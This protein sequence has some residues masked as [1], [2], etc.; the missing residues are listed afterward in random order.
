MKTTNARRLSRTLPPL[1][2]L[3]VMVPGTAMAA[4]ADWRPTYDLVMLWVNF[5]IFSGVLYKY[6]RE[7]IKRFLNQQK[8][9]V[10]SQ[11]EEIEAEK[12]RVVGEIESANVKAAENKRRVEK[13]KTRLIAQGEQR[14]QQIVEQAQQQSAVMMEQARKK[15]ETR[16]LQAK[17][18]LKMELADMAFEQ[19]VQRLP[20]IITA[21]DN[22]RLL[23]I[24]MQGLHL[25]EDAL[26]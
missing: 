17:S 21:D 23:D 5:A 3:L 4:T 20:Q 18:N 14:K 7:P 24:Y 8:Q 26:A 13:M 10:A 25:E 9:D 22:Q 15:M 6:T 2:F 16:I 12:K 11:I 1:V 19:A